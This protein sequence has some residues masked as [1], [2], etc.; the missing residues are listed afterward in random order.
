MH[1]EKIDA[2]K[3][4]T[5]VISGAVIELNITIRN[6]GLYPPGHFVREESA[7]KTQ[8]FL[9]R[10]FDLKSELTLGMAG[11]TL[12]VDGYALEGNPV[13][14]DFARALH[15]KGIAALT[16][17]PGITT[18]EILSMGELF[19]A[20]D[21]PFGAASAELAGHGDMTHIK[22]IPIDVSGFRLA[23]DSMQSNGGGRR[24][25]NIWGEYISRL[26]RG[27]LQAWEAKRIDEIPPAVVA[28]AIGAS[29]LKEDSYDRVISAYLKDTKGSPLDFD[30]F[31][32]FS[33]FIGGL[34][35]EVKKSFVDKAFVHLERDAVSFEDMLS[36]LTSAEFEKIVG[37][38]KEDITSVP[39]TIKNL[40]EKLAVAKN[41]IPYDFDLNFERSVVIDD[42][43]MDD[44]LITLLSSGRFNDFVGVDYQRD[45]VAMQR[46]KG[47]SVFAADALN[48]TFGVGT[49]DNAVTEVLLEL[50]ESEIAGEEDHTGLFTRLKEL[51]REFLY[52]GR[53]EGLLNIHNVIYPHLLGGRFKKEA[54]E[55]MEFF[56][57]EQFTAKLVETFR[58]WGKKERESAVK[59]AKAL[60]N[61]LIKP[62]IEAVV[63][64]SVSGTRR[65]L[66][67][68][69]SELGKPVAA[70]AAKR[71]ADDR[72][73]VVRNMIYLI[74]ECGGRDHEAILRLF[75]SHGNEKVRFEAVRTLLSF[76]VPDAPAL[77][78]PYL[79]SHDPE[80]HA[81]GI[82]L[83]GAYRLKSA[84]P[85]LLKLLGRKGLSDSMYRTKVQLLKALGEIGDEGAI[86]ALAALYDSKSLLHKEKLGKLK[87]EIFRSLANYPP[88]ALRPLLEAGLKSKNEEI[89]ALSGRLINGADIWNNQKK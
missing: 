19:A 18:R 51:S 28:D 71:I 47:T 62:L 70:E 65:F 42:I 14:R 61:S 87:A 29:P 16:F 63:V 76:D 56:R 84:V 26:L 81:R 49:V 33:R 52:T 55:I 45:M 59:L 37:F 36:G 54:A 15:E 83:A 75:L 64:E 39:E 66:L 10:L 41:R 57:S 38:F 85:A 43:E 34:S 2:V 73:Y 86:K 11:D 69:L 32:K 20:S 67:S 77:I 72:W 40:V 3:L 9:K 50:I 68:L 23:G 27:E 25:R 46:A 53:F 89:R 21:A 35:A 7:R 58:L 82:K 88:L 5:A 13:L 30:A 60:R 24:G 78:E 12:M 80:L 79:K 22:I 6:A 17:Y 8:R 48:L 4:D 1:G 74:R 31:E 44:S